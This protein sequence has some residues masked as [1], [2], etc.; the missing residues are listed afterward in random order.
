MV[1]REIRRLFLEGVRRLVVRRCLLFDRLRYSN[2][3]F[4]FYCALRYQNWIKKDINRL[5]MSPNGCRTKGCD[6]RCVPNSFFQIF[7]FLPTFL[8][9]RQI[10]TVHL[11]YTTNASNFISVSFNII[12][13]YSISSINCLFRNIA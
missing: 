10:F 6:R 5:E 1:Y 13:L 9:T 7:I 2:S 8:S 12:I 11:Y 4:Q 3:Y